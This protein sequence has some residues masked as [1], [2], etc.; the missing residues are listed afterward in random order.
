M[1]TEEL[2]SYVFRKPISNMFSKRQGNMLF[3]AHMW[4]KF[5]G[6]NRLLGKQLVL[7]RPTCIAGVEGTLCEREHYSGIP[8]E[9]CVG[10]ALH[11]LSKPTLTS[12]PTQPVGRHWGVSLTQL[13]ANTVPLSTPAPLF[14][15]KHF[16]NEAYQKMVQLS[17]R[18]GSFS[19]GSIVFQLSPPVC[20][21]IGK[22]VVDLGE[23]GRGEWEKQDQREGC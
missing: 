21:S 1:R 4:G 11:S 23:F 7:S 22:A 10:V 2:I 20:E 16:Q 12:G 8:S 19:F 13:R 17:W 6:R 15:P 9:E 3:F 18:E 14:L 5:E